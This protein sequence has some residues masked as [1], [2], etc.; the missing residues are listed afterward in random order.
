M[1]DRRAMGDGQQLPASSGA[2]GSSAL[3]SRNPQY[4]GLLQREGGLIQQGMSGSAGGPGSMSLDYPLLGGPGG[5]QGGGGGGGGGSSTAA[6]SPQQRQQQS[7]DM[8]TAQQMLRLIQ[9]NSLT[10][11]LLS[12]ATA[13]AMAGRGGGAGGPRGAGA[14]VAGGRPSTGRPVPTVQQPQQSNQRPQT[15]VQPA[16]GAG[17]QAQLGPLSQRLVDQGTQGLQGLQQQ[18]G[19]GWEVPT[20]SGSTASDGGAGSPGSGQAAANTVGGN[21]GGGVEQRE[22]TLG[23]GSSGGTG[24]GGGGGGGGGSLISSMNS[25]P[26]GSEGASPLRAERVEGVGLVLDPVSLSNLSSGDILYGL[27]DLYNGGGGQVPTVAADASG[28]SDDGL[29]GAG[30]GGG[31]GAGADPETPF[32]NTG[33]LQSSAA[34]VED[35]YDSDVYGMTGTDYRAANGYAIPQAGPAAG[36]KKAGSASSPGQL[37]ANGRSS[38]G[39]ASGGGGLGSRL[40]TGGGLMP[41]RRGGAGGGP[42]GNRTRELFPFCQPPYLLCAD[43]DLV[44]FLGVTTDQVIFAP[45]VLQYTGIGSIAERGMVATTTPNFYD[46][47]GSSDLTASNGLRYSANVFFNGFNGV[48]N[49]ELQLAVCARTFDRVNYKPNWVLTGT[50]PGLATTAVNFGPYGNFLIPGGL[51]STFTTGVPAAGGDFSFFIIIGYG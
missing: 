11:S 40:R 17:G 19:S 18:W 25:G 10:A 36:P 34:N 14:V 20:G 43:R 9:S 22:W 26:A 39:V 49:N 46:R 31:S 7:Q 8:A 29:S 1:Y 4:A 37:A 38:G 24:G 45:T 12:P 27:Y 6:L 44:T 33:P 3:A 50:G 35:E 21:S 2:I 13:A 47:T 51:S 41:G 42:G 23:A 5:S 16:A 15:A 28:G 32:L 48:T 30:A